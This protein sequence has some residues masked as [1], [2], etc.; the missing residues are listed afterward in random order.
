MRFTRIPAGDPRYPVR[1][2]LCAAQGSSARAPLLHPPSP[3]ALQCAVCPCPP[4][5]TGRLLIP[6]PIPLPLKSFVTKYV[7]RQPPLEDHR[8]PCGVA[9]PFP[10]PPWQSYYR[11]L[12]VSP[13]IRDYL[14]FLLRLEAT[15]FV[16]RA[17][18]GYPHICRTWRGSRESAQR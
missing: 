18:P 14:G 12:D 8:H 10:S 9:R 13:I 16:G 3:K 4:E 6:L 2:C 7:T 5:S 11:T 15:R 1:R 17:V